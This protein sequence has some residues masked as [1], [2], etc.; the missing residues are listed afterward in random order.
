MAVPEKSVWW[1]PD[2]LFSYQRILQRA[3]RTA[4]GGVTLIFSLYVGSGPA[5]TVHLKIKISG[6]SSTPKIF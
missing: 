4:G 1:G 3:V 2:N 6:I 5:S